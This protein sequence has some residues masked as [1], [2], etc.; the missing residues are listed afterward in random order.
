METEVYNIKGE[1]TGRKVSLPESIFNAQPNQ[2]V[3]YLDVKRYLAGQRQGTHKT[4]ERDE[5]R[6]STRKLVRQKG[7][8][9]ARRGSIK[10]PLLRGGGR[11]FGPQP[12]DYSFKLNKKVKHLARISAL[13]LKAKSNAITVLEDFTFENPKTKNYTELL[14]NFQL[15]GKKTLLVMHGNDKNIALSA[16]NIKTA[17][18][19]PVHLLNTYDIMNANYLLLHESSVKI[20]ENILTENEKNETKEILAQAK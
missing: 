9:G 18:V 17:K 13:S 5:V 19:A 6:G 10:S 4:K 1:K 20:I 2:H 3:L 16:R 7:S 8:G 11:I 14:G 15:H 12:R